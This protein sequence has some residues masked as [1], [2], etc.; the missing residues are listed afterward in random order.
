M[1]IS[2]FVKQVNTTKDAVRHYEELDLLRPSWKND[3][4]YYSPKDVG[5]FHAIKEMQS[6][7]FSLK[8][9]QAIFNLKRTDGCGSEKLIQGFLDSL[10]KELEAVVKAE[11]ELQ[12]KKSKITNMILE[13]K[14]L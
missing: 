10:D 8:D 9:V 14:Q 5:D 3:V 1:K 13:L 12:Q 4:R 2:E 6:V 11:E 7:G